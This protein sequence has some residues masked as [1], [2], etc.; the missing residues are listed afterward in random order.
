MISPH[1]IAGTYA[2]Q[3]FQVY[4]VSWDW[5]HIEG[6]WLDSDSGAPSL[7]IRELT[8]IHQKATGVSQISP[9]C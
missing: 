2:S 3:G 1:G 7:S 6:I 8:I 4:G 5:Q 9:L